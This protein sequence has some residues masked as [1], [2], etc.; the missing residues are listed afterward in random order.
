[1]VFSVHNLESK[2]VVCRKKDIIRYITDCKLCGK[3]TKA[4]QKKHYSQLVILF[5][6]TKQT[7]TNCT[8]RLPLPLIYLSIKKFF[9]KI[10]EKVYF[11]MKTPLQLLCNRTKHAHKMKCT[12]NFTKYTLLISGPRKHTQDE[13][14]LT[15]NNFVC[16]E[17]KHIF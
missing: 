10:T 12:S 4:T 14:H 7:N 16:F 13:M 11:P 9:L 3:R 6:F 2:L 15:G 1:M 5:S 17:N 8:S